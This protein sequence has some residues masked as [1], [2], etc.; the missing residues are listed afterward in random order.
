MKTCTKCKETK[1]LSEYHKQLDRKDKHSTHCKECRSKHSAEKRKEKANR[2]W[3]KIGTTCTRCCKGF[4]RY[5][6]ELHHVDPKEKDKN[7]SAMLQGS[8]EALEKELAKCV[9]L[10]ACC[11]RIVHYELRTGETVEL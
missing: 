11:H 8:W 4:P 5:V 7:V 2:L 10:C 1:E 6:L 3:E 9:V